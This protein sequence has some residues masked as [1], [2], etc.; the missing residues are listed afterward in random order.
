MKKP[1]CSINN[2]FHES[3]SLFCYLVTKFLNTYNNF[4]Q[5]N[6]LIEQKAGVGNQYLGVS[7]KC[8]TFVK[9]GNNP[10]ILEPY[11]LIKKTIALHFL[12]IHNNL[13]EQAHDTYRIKNR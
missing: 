5:S 3:K 4:N 8:K 10:V 13:K 2:S 9:P 12:R 1:F 6:T 11:S 7:E